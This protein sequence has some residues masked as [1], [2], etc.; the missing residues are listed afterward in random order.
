MEA[1]FSEEMA[2]KGHT[3]QSKK[4]DEDPSLVRKRVIEGE[5]GPTTS[6]TTMGSVRKVRR[7]L[8]PHKPWHELGQHSEPLR[9]PLRGGLNVFRYYKN[10]PGA[11]T[12]QRRGEAFAQS[13]KLIH[14][15]RKVFGM[16]KSRPFTRDVILPRLRFFKKTLHFSG[17]WEFCR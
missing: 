16:L 15:R 11:R 7:M 17:A 13:D 10:R 14:G 9:R 6:P 1:A 3:T 12:S 4:E 2:R 5:Q 8:C